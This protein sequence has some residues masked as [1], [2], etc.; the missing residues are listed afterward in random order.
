MKVSGRRMALAAAALVG[1]TIPGRTA[2]ADILPAVGT[3]TVTAVTGGF[4]WDYDILLVEGE[5][6][7][8]GDFFTIYDF[9]PGKVISMPA[10][11][12]V[13][14]DPFAPLIGQAATGDVVPTQGPEL[15]YTFTWLGGVVDGPMNL[16][17]FVIFSAIGTSEMRAFMGRDSDQDTDLLN[18]NITNTFVPTTGPEPGTIVLLGTGLF[19]LAAFAGRRRRLS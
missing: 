5:E 2:R 17:S 13:S 19:A 3:P 16:G 1:L 12:A 8:S 7:S 14:M 18:A 10:N 4:N 9:G 15:N 6:L 11:W